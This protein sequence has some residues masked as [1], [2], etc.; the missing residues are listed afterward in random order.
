MAGNSPFRIVKELDLGE[1]QAKLTQVEHIAS[2]AVILH[3]GNDDPE[4]LFCLSFRTYPDSSNGAPH[5]LEHTV[6]CGS[7]KFPVRDP[8]FSMTRRSMATFMNAMT[9]DDTTFYPASSQIPKDLYN[10]LDVYIDAVFFPTLSRVSFLQEGHRLEFADLADSSSP[11][12]IK[13]IVYNEMK[14]ALSSPD[15][16]LYHGLMAA[17]FPDTP[18]GYNS[19]GDPAAIRTLTYEQLV[20]F[21]K[22]YYHPSRC[23]FFFYGNLP[24]QDHLDYLEERL[25][26]HVDPLPLP[27]PIPSQP[28]FSKPRALEGVYPV[29]EEAEEERGLLAFGWLTCSPTDPGELLALEVIDLLLMATDASPLKEALL[30]S[31]LCKQANSYLDGDNRDVPWIFIL[32]GLD[33]EDGEAIETLLL[34]RVEQFCNEPIPQRAID[35]AIHQLEFDRCEINGDGHPYGL[36]LFGRTV[37]LLQQGG[38]PED[39]LR[40][41]TLFE[42]LRERCQTQGYLTGLLRR[43][44][45]DN[46]HRVRLV[47]RPD[48]ELEEREAEEEEQ[49]LAKQA[50]SLTEN[51]R[52]AIVAASLE[53]AALQEEEERLDSL[54]KISLSDVPSKAP[55]LPLTKKEA[56]GLTR[57]HH[58]CFTNGVGYLSACF[59]LPQVEPADLPWLRLFTGM[60]SQV[61]SGGRDYRETLDAILEHTGGIGADLSLHPHATNF[62]RFQPT[63][64]LSGRA[65][66]RKTPHLLTLMKEMATSCDF[67]DRARLRELIGKLYTGLEHSLVRNALPYATSIASAGISIASQIA[68]SWW[69]LT[70]LHAIRELNGALEERMDGLIAKL[71][72]FRERLFRAEGGAL[73]ISGSDPFVDEVERLDYGGLTQLDLQRSPHLSTA[74]ELVESRSQGLVVASPVAFTCK[75]I[76]CVS[77]NHP[78][79]PL[80]SVASRLFVDKV[81][82]KR[83]REQ[84]GAYGSGA[85]CNPLFGTFHFY[86]YRDPNLATSLDAFDEAITMGAEGR[87]DAEELEEAKLRLLQ[88]MDSP[89]SPGSRAL[90]AYGRLREGKS[91]AMRQKFREK[92]LSATCDE[93]SEAVRTHLVKK[94]EGAI[95]VAAA[96]RDFLERENKALEAAGREALPIIA[97]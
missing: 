78:D 18:Y 37:P 24:L 52:K 44:L 76:P 61:G 32:R 51:D 83:I 45:L 94:W 28:R 43:Y 54:P 82:H 16:R 34:K 57:Y 42:T 13:G 67:Q 68:E 73:V 19:G 60:V 29:S 93:V 58:D 74:G 70:F 38:L 3:I 17:L 88:K 71:E 63:I 25:L 47:L 91:D 84:G 77:Y 8:F 26:S 72:Q 39:G 79:A 4:N 27:P 40:I 86:A 15:S 50:E 21:H 23:T 1:I 36:S 65:L 81:L 96:N 7:K 90:T 31:G 41:H 49:W 55:L 12:E 11:L 80:L 87:F 85:S 66:E 14:G 53:L 95:T 89:I 92:I 6:L 10:L 46:P 30:R 22:S 20:D 69:G 97:A 56:S 75:L 2:G 48:S 5:I 33:P 9:G 64:S 62:H 35:A 59:D